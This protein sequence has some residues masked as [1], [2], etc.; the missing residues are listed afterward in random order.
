MK[1]RYSSDGVHLFDRFSGTN[2]LLDEMKI[3]EGKFSSAPRQVSI[4]LTNACDL[5]C[6]HCYAPKTAATLSYDILTQWLVELDENG[7]LGIGF[8]GG[9]PTLY[10]RFAELCDFAQNETGLAVTF[11]THGHRLTDVLLKEIE[12]NV[13]FVRVS[14]DGVNDTYERIR[15]RSFSHLLDRLSALRHRIP[16][17][18]NY[19]I[20]EE[21]IQDL[22]SASEL[23]ESH[24]AMELLMLPE[25][26]S[27]GKV[28][29]SENCLN[30]LRNWIL[31]Y[32]GGLRIAI[33]EGNEA[34][35][36]VCDA[37]SDNTGW[38][39]YAHI[40]AMGCLKRSS[41]Y[42]VGTLINHSILETLVKRS[43]NS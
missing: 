42:Q 16:F 38:S 3:P 14:M 32:K 21:T 2:I 6:S 24:G 7:T 20:N 29:I 17:G 31:D 18:I 13:N 22:D 30:Q 1:V 39:A 27:T 9:E 10:P 37:L 40:D 19:V 26:E 12:G 35:L 34:S 11:T 33:S 4:A 5:K 41:Y 15:G 36:P 43:K 8:G 25:V 28:K 23:V